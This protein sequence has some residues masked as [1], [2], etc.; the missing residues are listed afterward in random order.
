ME[1]MGD[2]ETAYALR[3]LKEVVERMSV[4]PDSAASS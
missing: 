1:E 4:L 2:E 3:R